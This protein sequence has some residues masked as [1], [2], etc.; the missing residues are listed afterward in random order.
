MYFFERFG[1]L[2]VDVENVLQSKQSLILY[3]ILSC[4]QEG[5]FSHSPPPSHLFLPFLQQASVSISV[6]W[7]NMRLFGKV[8][9]AVYICRYLTSV[10]SLIVSY[11]APCLVRCHLSLLL[12]FAWLQQSENS[13]SIG[14]LTTP[15]AGKVNRT[16]MHG[17][18][19]H[20]SGAINHPITQ[21][22]YILPPFVPSFPP[23]I[24]CVHPLRWFAYSCFDCEKHKDRNRG[25]QRTWIAICL[26]K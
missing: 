15:E 5:V 17:K 13:P 19:L 10:G 20:P 7:V 4:F 8:L 1:L 2:N 23:Q 22:L 26:L 24:W 3:C 21:R 11:L 6:H 14:Q 9:H 25:K 12:T 16:L 18:E